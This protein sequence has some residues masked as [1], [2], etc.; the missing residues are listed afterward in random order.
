MTNKKKSNKMVFI[1]AGGVALV[2][3]CV[4][5]LVVKV[6]LSS[7]SS[8]RQR[9]IQ[10]VT[11]M[12][13]P[14]TPKVKE[15]EPEPEIE[16]EEE[17]IEQEMDEPEPEP[18]E[19]AASDEPPPGQDLGLDADGSG[20]SDSFG[21]KAKKGAR[22]LIGGSYSESSLLKKYA[23]YTRI[24]QEELREKVNSYMEGNGGIPDGDL[25]AIVQITLDENGNILDFKIA[26]SSGSADMDAAVKTS[27]ESAQI[28]E[29]PPS[30]M[31]KTIKLKISA[32]G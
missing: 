4:V 32:R 7:D 16:K 13:P 9:Q 27:L 21:L 23:W 12:T 30:N 20:G 28:S 6:L 17:I 19:D 18:M 2:M 3:I 22:S 10:Q 29:A 5:V 15:K 11:L 31:P 25:N 14:P 8:G 1:V 26:T 24:V